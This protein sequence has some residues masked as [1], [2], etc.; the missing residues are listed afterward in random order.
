M[1]RLFNANT[2]RASGRGQV[3][4]KPHLHP[5]I[6]YDLHEVK[7]CP[8]TPLEDQLAI[9]LRDDNSQR[10]W[11][12]GPTLKSL[13]LSSLWK[14]SRRPPSKATMCL[15][16]PKPLGD[17]KKGSASIQLSC[18][19]VSLG[20]VPSPPETGGSQ[21]DW[22]LA[23]GLRVFLEAPR[24]PEGGNLG[25]VKP[26]GPTTWRSSCHLAQHFE[27]LEGCTRTSHSCMARAGNVCC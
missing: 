10:L 15:D 9:R 13:N 2:V 22:N 12:Q 6:S 27:T 16:L 7:P 11:G 26:V 8:L 1:A 25:P 19:Y 4:L 24:R 17:I 14:S 18:P 21:V 5:T 3:V 23:R 20:R